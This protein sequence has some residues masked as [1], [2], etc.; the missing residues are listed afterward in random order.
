MNGWKEL[1]FTLP[2]HIEGKEN[3]RNKFLHGEYLVRLI[4]G[5]ET[6]WFILHAPS[7][8]HKGMTAL[9][10]VTCSHVSSLLNRKNLFLYFDDLNG[11]GTAQELLEKVLENTGWTLGVC[12]TFLE[13]DG[14]T[15]KIRTLKAE[16][17]RGAYLLISDI[18]EL[19]SGY[20]VF[21]G[22]TRT[23]DIFS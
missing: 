8:S 21:H 11:I 12:E 22:D 18:C 3:W 6:D 5:D 10:E 19:F 20:P 2:F 13:R 4:S 15:E 9:Y 14:K 23:V 1:T 7:K 16:A 17:K